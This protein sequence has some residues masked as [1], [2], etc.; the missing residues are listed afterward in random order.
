VSCVGG[1]TERDKAKGYWVAIVAPN[2]PPVLSSRSLAIV[3]RA[4]S[5]LVACSAKTP[6]GPPPAPEVTAI[7]VQVTEVPNV[8]ELPGRIEA[9]RTH[10]H[11]RS[12]ILSTRRGAHETMGSSGSIAALFRI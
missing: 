11:N 6:A 3:L 8:I 10:D 9:V 2:A 5:F 12:L 7:T 1:S 4:A